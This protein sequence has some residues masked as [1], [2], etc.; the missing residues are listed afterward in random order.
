MADDT[1]HE[2]ADIYNRHPSSEP[3]EVNYETGKVEE[4]DLEAKAEAEAEAETVE[5]K[6]RRRGGRGRKKA[7][8][9][10]VVVE[11]EEAAPTAAAPE[12][13]A[14][15]APAAEEKPKR[16]DRRSAIRI[17]PVGLPA[18]QLELIYDL[19]G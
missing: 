2:N 4:I 13:V 5:K 8:D 14:E 3:V 7:D 16:K 6:P 12:L 18:K 15:D 17:R 11:V 10:E 1:K 9:A 19:Q